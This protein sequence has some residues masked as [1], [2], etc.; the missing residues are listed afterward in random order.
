MPYL[1]IATAVVLLAVLLAALLAPSTWPALLLFVLVAGCAAWEWLRLSLPAA[2]AG[3]ALPAALALAAVLWALAW[4]FFLGTPDRFL[5]LAL[6]LGPALVVLLV[7]TAIGWLLG[8]PV[9]LWRARV[10][11]RRHTLLLSLAGLAA[12]ASLWFALAW[13]YAMRGA[14]FLVSLLALIWFAD[15]VAYFAGRAWG[16]RRLAPAISPG[17]TWE[18]ALAG[19]VG[20][21]LWMLASAFWGNSFSAALVQGWGWVGM[22]AISVLLAAVSIAGDLFESLLKR[23]AGVKDSSQLLPGHG[24][25]LD[26]IDALLPVAPLA[27]LLAGLR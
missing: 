15:S 26:R 8:L 13:F 2:R 5:T 3:L 10:Q 4:I 1:R 16:R 22:V 7:S 18:G 6:R 19:I 20:A 21:V 27:L 11:E 17:K 24:G 9:C 12:V 14:W 25:V 23:R